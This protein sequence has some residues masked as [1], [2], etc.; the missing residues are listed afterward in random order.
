MKKAK[1]K[2]SAAKKGGTAL[3]KAKSA[4]PKTKI[5]AAEADL[6]AKLSFNH[7]MIYARDVG[8]AI[9]FYRDLLGFKVIEDFRHENQS[10]YARLRAPGEREPS[11]CIKRR[12]ER[13]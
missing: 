4:A 5:G 1:T 11:P 7:A 3:A 12:R 13:R 9:L 6:G 10:V 2:K 8:K